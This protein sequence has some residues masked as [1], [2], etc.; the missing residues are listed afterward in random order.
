MKPLRLFHTTTPVWTPLLGFARTLFALSGLV[1]LLFNSATDLFRPASGIN[2]Y[3]LCTGTGQYSLFCLFESV[4]GL[5]VMRWICIALLLLVIVGV[6]PRI[7]AFFHFWVAF[8]L[9]NSSIIVDGGDQVTVVATFLLLPL[10]LTDPRKNH[11]DAP[12]NAVESGSFY[13]KSIAFMAWIALQVQACIIYLEAF[14]MKFNVSEWANGTALYYWLS[15]PIVGLGISHDSFFYQGLLSNTLV[16]SLLTWGVLLLEMFLFMG[17]LASSKNKLRLFIMGVAFHFM[18]ILIH[19][20]IS[21][22]F[23][24]AGILCLYLLNYDRFQKI[25]QWL[26]PKRS[27]TYALPA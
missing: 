22:F 24:M 20:L 16:I 26:Q 19:G 12:L 5:E 4:A 13:R 3:P 14:F 21:F 9:F 7:T 18:I 11:W 2:D 27:K 25:R 17:L 1:T 6:Y 8:S 15:D 10:C 23:A